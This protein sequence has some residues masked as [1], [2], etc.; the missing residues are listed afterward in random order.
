MQSLQLLRI[1]KVRR[2]AGYHNAVRGKF[3]HGEISAAGQSPGAVMRGVAV[4]DDIDNQRMLFVFLKFLVRI[5]L[6]VFRTEMSDK[7]DDNFAFGN[8]I[9]KSAA[10][11]PFPE[12]IS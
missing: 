2:V 12:R 8:A 1:D 10:G 3:R 7:P 6:R 4:F 9:Y 11:K 5:E